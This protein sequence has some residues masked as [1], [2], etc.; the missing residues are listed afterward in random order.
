MATKCISGCDKAEDAK[1]GIVRRGTDYFPEEELIQHGKEFLN[2]NPGFSTKVDPSGIKDSTNRRCAAAAL[3]VR[4][5]ACKRGAGCEGTDGVANEATSSASQPPCAADG[6]D[7]FDVLDDR[8]LQHLHEKGYVVISEVMS[9]EQL[10]S[11]RSQIWDGIEATSPGV[12][13]TDAQSWHQWQLDRRG[14]LLQ[15]SVTQG[16]GV[17]G[18]RSLPKI[19]SVFEQIWGTPALIVSMDAVIAWRPWWDGDGD[20][21]T[22]GTAPKTG[23][24]WRSRRD[25]GAAAAAASSSACSS[26]GSWFPSPVPN[27]RSV[28]VP[29]VCSSL[30]ILS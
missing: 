1:Q 3:A 21:D 25:L 20:G 29:T 15:S 6:I 26:L 10:V 27:V 16:A 24:A 14:F 8:W 22:V 7:R 11:T 18:V 4:A 17:W 12:S 13:R 23:G 30:T 2:K 9:I 19:R 5:Q 28:A